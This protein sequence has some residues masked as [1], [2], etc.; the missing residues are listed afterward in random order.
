M[1]A[2]ELKYQMEIAKK[3]KEE[4]KRKKKEEDMKLEIKMQEIIEKENQEGNKGPNLK[5]VSKSKLKDLYGVDLKEDDN[6]NINNNP[7]QPSLNLPESNL[8]NDQ[9]NESKPILT[10]DT[11]QSQSLIQQ[12]I[13]NINDPNAN[14]N[15]SRPMTAAYNTNHSFYNQNTPS[16]LNNNINN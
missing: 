5:K 4:E 11:T 1:Y 6:A 16:N 9:Q 3:K 7:N 10:S 15:I 2:D 14:A 13:N 12:D 8:Q